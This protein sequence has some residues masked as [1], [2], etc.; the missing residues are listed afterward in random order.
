MLIYKILL[1]EEWAEFEAL[2]EFRGSAF[3]AES[4]FV[5]CSAREQLAGVGQRLFAHELALVVVVLE[6]ER[7]GH[8]V[9]WEPAPHGGLFPHVY[10]ALPMDAVTDVL[11][12]EGVL[13]VERAA[14]EAQTE[15]AGS[16]LDEQ[17]EA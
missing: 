7:L 2:G 4:G 16:G 15:T 17:A 12:V 6:T 1:P 8:A 9:R 14:A 5:H 10:A 3:D 11:H 13:G